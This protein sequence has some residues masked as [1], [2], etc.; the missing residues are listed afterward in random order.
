MN[1]T[2]NLWGSQMEGVAQKDK[3]LHRKIQ[4]CGF[5]IPVSQTGAKVGKLQ[6]QIE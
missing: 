1:Y 5:K 4:S 6:Y 3:K 2:R